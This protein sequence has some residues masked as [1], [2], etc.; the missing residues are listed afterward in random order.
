M[1]NEQR[2]ELCNKINE[3]LKNK[4]SYLIENDKDFRKLISSKI[5]TFND[6]IGSK[7]FG[8]WLSLFH[9]KDTDT[10]NYVI[11][12]SKSKELPIA[13]YLELLNERLA[14]HCG[15]S[16]IESKI[17][18][19]KNDSNIYGI[20]SEDYRKF[21]Y[22]TIGGKDI[23][24]KFLKE[25]KYNVSDDYELENINIDFNINSLP[26]IYQALNYFF[27]DK[28]L[29]NGIN[30]NSLKASSSVNIIFNEL[31]K[32][33]VFSYI[34]MQKDFH[35]DNWEILYN[36]HSAYLSPMY[37]LELSMNES[38]YD[39]RFNTSMKWSREKDIDIDQDFQNFIDCSE[40][41][42][43]LVINMHNVLTIDDVIIFMNDIQNRGI[44]IDESKKEEIIKCF[45]EHY[46]KIN[47]MLYG[48]K[49]TLK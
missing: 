23:I 7:Y 27:Y 3:N 1:T 9:G 46:D 45:S 18:K 8:Y 29:D 15:L 4:D 14:T 33:Y 36:E 2:I 22:T 34:T 13:F 47:T 20:I 5:L 39:E 42:K 26:V 44:I 30:Y 6:K 12:I 19:Y 43:N 32:R 48:Q 38:F 28:V 25:I 24:Y 35:L 40:E 11:K 17:F 10:D 49:N 21:G 31:V 37:D 16:T 41:N